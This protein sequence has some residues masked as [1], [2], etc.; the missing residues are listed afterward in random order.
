MSDYVV[1]VGKLETSNHKLDETMDNTTENKD[2]VSSCNF[3]D[4]PYCIREKIIY[5]E[6]CD[7]LSESSHSSHSSIEDKFSQNDSCNKKIS[8][9]VFENIKTLSKAQSTKS[10]LLWV[11]E[12]FIS[13]EKIFIKCLN[14]LCDIFASFVKIVGDNDKLVSAAE[15]S[16]IISPLPQLL[17]INQILLKEM[18][19]RLEN[20]SENPK[21]ADIIVQKG[22]FLKLYSFY[23]RNYSNN[24][25]LFEE[26]CQKHP[27]LQ[28]SVKD[29]EM[30][31][32]SKK[33]AIRHYMLKPIQ[34]IPQYRLLL[35]NYLKHQSENSVDYEDT[36]KAL[37]IVSD[38]ANHANKSIRKGVSRY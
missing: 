19:L 24:C 35:E 37:E 20:W 1:F 38:V 22:P 28:K 10:K 2:F 21:I 6:D 17:S 27:Q 13:S 9:N 33:L 4:Q 18:E 3:K 15:L 11:V 25:T 14:L 30:S 5:K 34:R 7:S 23:I 26:F 36:I 16:K 31:D 8:E 32:A 12:E 29:F